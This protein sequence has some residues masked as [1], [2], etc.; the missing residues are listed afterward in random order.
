MAL[1]GHR[2]FA[3]YCAPED[4]THMTT[5]GEKAYN[6]EIEMAGI[7]LGGVLGG[8]AFGA[9]GD[10]IHSEVNAMAWY[11]TGVLLGAVGGFIAS[12][13]FRA[14]ALGGDSLRG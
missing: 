7:Y 4:A 14:V 6:G 8:F 5:D 11:V 10:I 3:P 2:L 9:F 12:K 1:A 13:V